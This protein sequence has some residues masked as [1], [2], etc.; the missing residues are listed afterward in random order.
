MSGG[1]LFPCHEKV[2]QMFEPTSNHYSGA[3]N[4]KF[5]QKMF[6]KRKHHYHHYYHH[7][8]HYRHHHRRHYHP[9]YHHHH[10]LSAPPSANPV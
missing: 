3:S 6:I 5:L 1:L 4:T 2:E 10:S 9:F 7:H 8:H